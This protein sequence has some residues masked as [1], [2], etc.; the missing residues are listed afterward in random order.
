[1]SAPARTITIVMHNGNN[2]DVFVG[3]RSSNGLCWDEMLGQIASMTHPEIRKARYLM[4]T[5]EEREE[6]R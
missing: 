3:Q 5:P 1:M 2:F 4:L 6:R